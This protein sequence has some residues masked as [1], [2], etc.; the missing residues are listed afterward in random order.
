MGHFLVFEKLIE[1]VIFSSWW[2]HGQ[3]HHFTVSLWLIKLLYFTCIQG[4]YFGHSKILLRIH[5]SFSEIVMMKSGLSS[6]SFLSFRQRSTGLAFELIDRGG[7]FS[8]QLNFFPWM[9]S[10]LHFYRRI[11]MSRML[12]C[13]NRL[14]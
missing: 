10:S 2:K 4:L 12:I 13:K 9:F 8:S 5:I 14:S 1:I 3:W 6:T 7:L 11:F